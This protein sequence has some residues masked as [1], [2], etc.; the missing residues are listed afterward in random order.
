MLDEWLCK[1]NNNN[2]FVKMLI[3]RSYRQFVYFEY[4]ICS[5]CCHH[6]VYF[7]NKLEIWFMDH[8]HRKTSKIAYPSKY[9]MQFIAIYRKLTVSYCTA[10]NIWCF[11]VWSMNNE[12]LQVFFY[13]D[14]ESYNK[15]YFRAQFSLLFLLLNIEFL[16]LMFFS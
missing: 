6:P 10:M 1:R 15:V 11:P 2:V 16:M 13:F 7:C 8:S 9:N 12:F 4:L 5:H 3:L 14:L